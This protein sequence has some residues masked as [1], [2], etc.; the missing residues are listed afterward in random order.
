MPGTPTSPAPVERLA[1]PEDDTAPDSPIH[2][3]LEGEL[4]TCLFHRTQTADHLR[5]CLFGRVFREEEVMAPLART[6]ALFLQLSQTLIHVSFQTFVV[7]AANKKAAVF[8]GGLSEKCCVV[9]SRREAAFGWFLP[10]RRCQKG[11]AA[12]TCQWQLG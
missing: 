5:F 9:V 3:F 1:I 4:K 6:S 8:A 12:A 11:R 2:L 7:V 10:G